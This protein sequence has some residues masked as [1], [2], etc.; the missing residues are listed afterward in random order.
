MAFIYGTESEY[1]NTKRYI[2]YKREFILIFAFIVLLAVYV[3]KLGFFANLSLLP[4]VVSFAIIMVIIKLFDVF[5]LAQRTGFEKASRG[6]FGESY[7]LNTLKQLPDTYS[8]FRGL[9]LTGKHDIDFVVVGPTG[10]FTLEVKSHRGYIRF[11]TKVLTLNFRK[12][13][14]DILWQALNETMELHSFIKLQTNK[15]IFIN[16]VLVF[17]NPKTHMRFGLEKIR[18]VYVIN[19]KWII[20]LLTKPNG[21]FIDGDL[22]T[23]ALAAHYT[24]NAK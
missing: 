1:F 16:P 23:Q 8:I 7:V 24:A 17:S 2:F 3:Y 5:I 14:K 11:N 12:F 13:E 20:E 9:N 6:L 4:A 10:V 19:D 15:D 18:G 21:Y 22:V